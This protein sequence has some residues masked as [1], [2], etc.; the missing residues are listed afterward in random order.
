MNLQNTQSVSKAVTDLRRAI[1][2][3]LEKTPSLSGKQIDS[4]KLIV[5]ALD[6]NNVIAGAQMRASFSSTSSTS[7]STSGST[8]TE[9]NRPPDPNRPSTGTSDSQFLGALMIVGT[10]SQG[11]GFHGSTTEGGARTGDT[12]HPTEGAARTGAADTSMMHG[13]LTAGTY[14]V[15][16]AA[17]STSTSMLQSVEIVDSNQR[18][19]AT[20]PVMGFDF[21]TRDIGAVK[22]TTRDTTGGD[23]AN[24]RD[25]SQREASSGISGMQGMSGTNDWNKIYMSIVHHFQ[26]KFG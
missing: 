2:T 20:V 10:F 8:G 11:M 7:G 15:R 16:R 24:P 4:T 18:V 22:D 25:A 1:T 21:A 6:D 13:D 5:T 17:G 3:E 26:P 19:V 23:T 14:M 12:A 9:P